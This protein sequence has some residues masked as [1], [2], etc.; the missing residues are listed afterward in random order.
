VEQHGIID[1]AVASIVTI[2]LQYGKEVSV[3]KIREIAG[4]DRFGTAAYGV[5]KAAKNLGFEA[6]AVRAET[7]EAIFEENI[8]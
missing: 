2:C 6:K 4:T 5:V 1:C 7:K 8:Y 3:A